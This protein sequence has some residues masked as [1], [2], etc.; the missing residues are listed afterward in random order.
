MSAPRLRA[1]RHAASRHAVSSAL[2][3]S[4]AAM[5][6]GAALVV[7]QAP[8]QAAP[9]AAPL[10]PG[11]QAYYTRS[12]GASG[13]FGAL[14]SREVQDTLVKGMSYVRTANTAQHRTYWLAW[15]FGRPRAVQTSGAIGAYW[16][17]RRASLGA[18]VEWESCSAL[19]LCKQTFQKTPAMDRNQPKSEVLW[20]P[21]TGA[22]HTV[23]GGFLDTY[24]HQ[25]DILGS[26]GAPTD[27]EHLVDGHSV[28]TFLSLKTGTRTVLTWAPSEGVRSF[29]VG[30]AIGAVYRQDAASGSSLGVPRS[31][32][33]TG[34]KDGGVWQAFSRGRIY[35]TPATGAQKILN[36]PI[37]DHWADAGS[38]NGAWGYPTS[39]ARS[40]PLGVQQDFQGGT[41]TLFADGSVSFVPNATSPATSMDSAAAA[42]GLG[43]F[44]DTRTTGATDVS[45]RTYEHGVV[46][47]TQKH[48]AVAMSTQVFDW[49]K[50]HQS[51]AGLPVS[52]KSQDAHLVTSFESLALV[53]APERGNLVLQADDV[54]SSQDALVIGDSQLYDPSH[55]QSWVAQAIRTDGYATHYR[56]MGGDG[57]VVD[58]K[59]HFGSYHHGVV[60]NFWALPA[61]NPGVVYIQSSGNDSYGTPVAQIEEQTRETVNRLK[62][63]YPGARI[64]VSG[65]ISR[66]GAT[67]RDAVSAA[68][69][70]GT[71]GTG[72]VF[73]PLAGK[74][75]AWNAES[76][77]QEDGL[78]FRAPDGHAYMAAHYAP[79]LKGY[80][81][82]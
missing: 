68:A 57:M 1:P 18:P 78:H 77:L 11:L 73:V 31:N 38:E 47:W 12:G 62:A 14:Q 55:D 59:S 66:N 27:E 4:L 81:T 19:Q 6:M 79:Y 60:D 42:A 7:G 37:L 43:S 41:A 25:G 50:N 21:A 22:A 35:W 44:V 65:V 36:G 17:P 61:G 54:L 33:F 63:V 32:E 29:Q 2:P 82:D 34:K 8:A 5:V 26:L 30:G 74:I 3:T 40:T 72:A 45:G 13:T 49:W 51:A 39:G 64:V 48:G 71:A 23:S 16:V 80:L 75:T 76:Y 52:S 10:G 15:A 46:L 69:Q 70:R 20:S 28:Q 24:Y 53:W 67:A 58:N 9:A 56:A